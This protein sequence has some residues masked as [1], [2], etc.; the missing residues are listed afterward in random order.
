LADNVFL[1][2]QARKIRYLTVREIGT[3]GVGHIG[4]CLSIA[5]LL[6]VLY[7]D[8]MNIDPANPKKAERD[9]LVIS[10]AHAGPALYA[11]LS[12]RGYFD[13]AELW[14]L[15]K[16]NT[17]LPSHCDMKRTV[18]VDMT[19]GSLGQGISCG[20]GMALASRLRGYDAYVYAIVGDGES[21]EGQV[22]EAAMAASH[23][24]LDNFI[25]FL[26][27]NRLQIDGFTDDI[28]STGDPAARWGA[29]GFDTQEVDGHD[30]SAIS[31]AIGRAKRVKGKPSMLILHTV[32]G[33]GVSFIEAA[34]ATNHN[35]ILTP[36]QMETALAEINEAA[37]CELS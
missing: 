36:E 14:T 22:W 15:N 25:V 34:G 3:L 20:V 16:P 2:K 32:K 18:G 23:F 30:V 1:E 9:R 8:K 19:A 35:M 33:K 10:K 7:F 5:E 6:S 28:M 12:M 31:Q 26:D 21:Q 24:G 17:C 4:G 27:Y 13:E 29:F 11:A 37:G